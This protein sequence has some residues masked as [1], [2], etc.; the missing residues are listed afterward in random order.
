MNK[1]R[2]RNERLLHAIVDYLVDNIGN[3]TSV[4]SGAP[5]DMRIPWLM[6]MGDPSGSSA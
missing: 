2:F 4:R 1:Y 3:N 6:N 5:L